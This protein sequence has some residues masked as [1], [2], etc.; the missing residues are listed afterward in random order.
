M[1]PTGRL[2]LKCLSRLML[3]NS[4]KMLMKLEKIQE[5]T[6]VITKGLGNMFLEE[7][8]KGFNLFS[9]FNSMF[10]RELFTF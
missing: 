7:G 3:T 5:R 2:P 10:V 6:T 1:V 9:L 4:R 8:I